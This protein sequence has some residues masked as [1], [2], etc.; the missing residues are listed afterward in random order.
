D[1]NENSHSK[2]K[3]GGREWKK[4]GRSQ[5]AGNEG[6]KGR[7]GEPSYVKKKFGSCFTCGGPHLRKDCPVLAKVN[8]LAAVEEDKKA[9]PKAEEPVT[10]EDTL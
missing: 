8:A 5:A 10:Y 1:L 3:D 6:V 9:E 7:Q 2:P 4:E